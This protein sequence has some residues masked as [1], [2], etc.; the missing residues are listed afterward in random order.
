M[1][2]DDWYHRKFIGRQRLRRRLR[3]DHMVRQ[4]DDGVII[5][6][7]YQSSYVRRRANRKVRKTM[8]IPSGRCYA[9]VFDYWWEV[10]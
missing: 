1:N 3:W 10:T 7:S 6:S 9:R 5:A 2:R 4:R 8:N